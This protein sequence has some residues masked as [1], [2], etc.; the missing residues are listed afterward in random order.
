MLKLIRVCA[1][2]TTYEVPFSVS[3]LVSEPGYKLGLIRFSRATFAHLVGFPA[4]HTHFV[5][6]L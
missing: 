3:P 4:Y 2:S 6:V 5:L 1:M